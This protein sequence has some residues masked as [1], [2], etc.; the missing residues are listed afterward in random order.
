MIISLIRTVC[1]WSVAF[2]LSLIVFTGSVSAQ[3]STPV[4]LEPMMASESSEVLYQFPKD[5]EDGSEL[6]I[7]GMLIEC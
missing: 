1:A 2:C 3:D 7:E 5:V 6:V 4:D